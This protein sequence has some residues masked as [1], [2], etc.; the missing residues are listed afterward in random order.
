MLVFNT[1]FFCL[2]ISACG[3]SVKPEATKAATPVVVQLSCNNDKDQ[4]LAEAQ[5][6]SN[7][8]KHRQAFLKIAD[9]RFQSSDPRYAE[10]SKRYRTLEA[11]TALN[12]LP[13]ESWKERLDNLRIIK[14]NDPEWAE[15]KPEYDALEKQDGAQKHHAFEV[16]AAEAK[17]RHAAQKAAKAQMN[18]YIGMSAE[19]AREST[20]GEPHEINRTTTA[21][22]VHEQWVYGS[23]RFLYFTNGK[24]T[25][26]QD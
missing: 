17:A 18:V 10:R 23:K 4:L 24:L 1:T 13:K 11:R 26:I 6:L 5:A 12:S 9:C 20:W 3:Q 8:G 16:A 15:F 2:L 7:A 21:S 22:G 14:A 25:A 19:D